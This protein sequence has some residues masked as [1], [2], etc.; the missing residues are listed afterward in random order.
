MSSPESSSAGPSPRGYVRLGI[1][2][3]GNFRKLEPPMPP[4]YSPAPPSRVRARSPKTFSSGIGGAGNWRRVDQAAAISSYEAQVRDQVR[5]ESASDGFFFG[6]GGAGNHASTSPGLRST[7]ALGSSGP[8][9]HLGTV[10]S[11]STQSSDDRA[12][13]PRSSFARKLKSWCNAG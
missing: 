7:S 10:T 13:Q 9:Y 2:G 11:C 12:K 5:A 3:A 6:I 1:G 4:A 8:T